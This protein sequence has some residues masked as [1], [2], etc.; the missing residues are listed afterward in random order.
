MWCI[1]CRQDVPGLTSTETGR[2]QCPRCGDVVCDQ[3]PIVSPPAA[4]SAEAKE[5][6]PE[7]PL[8]PMDALGGDLAVPLPL[9]T[10]EL[11]EQL[12]RVSRLLGLYARQGPDAS[13]T[14][15]DPAQAAASGWHRQARASSRRNTGPNPFWRLAGVL[16]TTFTWLGTTALTCG[17]ILIAWANLAARHELQVIG[18]PIAVGG[19]V[20]MLVGLVVYLDQDQLGPQS[21]ATSASRRIDR[22]SARAGN[23]PHPRRPVRQRADKAA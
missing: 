6:V 12:R 22:H 13:Q 7:H 1:T 5:R 8:Q 10:W 23:G 21:V 4:P 2:Y 19:A 20:A 18:W 14:R 9:D 11:D 16:S 15:F 17:G 3:I